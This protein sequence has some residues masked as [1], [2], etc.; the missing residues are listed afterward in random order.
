MC[1]ETNHKRD[2][3]E[4]GRVFFDLLPSELHIIIKI[5]LK[6]QKDIY[7]I[8]GAVRDFLFRE[9]IG[10]FDL[11]TNALPKQITKLIDEVGAKTKPIGKKFGTVLAIIGKRAFDI[12]TF[13]HEHFKISGE[14]PQVDFVESL[15]E[16]LTRR[17]FTINAIAFDPKTKI[18]I[19]KYGGI[20]DINNYRLRVI[21]DAFIRFNEDGLRIIR[22]ARFMSQ[23]NLTPD[24]VSLSAIAKIGNTARFRNPDALRIELFKML[25]LPNPSSGLKLLWKNEIFYTIFSKFPFSKLQNLFPILDEGIN[26]FNEIPHRQILI[27][28]FGLLILFADESALSQDSWLQ[29]GNN[30]NLSQ[31]QREILNRLYQSWITFPFDLQSNELK[32]WVRRTGINTSEDILPLIFLK[33]KIFGDSKILDKKELYINRV[34]ELLSYFRKS[35]D[36]D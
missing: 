25:D 23:F 35:S 26:Q 33:A 30:L 14:P 6:H 28:L 2:L 11:A 29:I 3:K 31:K 10:D 27:R 21:G 22:F 5:F 15:D 1:G 18:F 32:H 9:T 20:D 17:D 34:N 4:K 12:S 19:D 24:S 7:I 16:D 8:G 36:G 13:R